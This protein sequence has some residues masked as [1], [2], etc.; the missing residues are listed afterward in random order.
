MALPA[1]LALGLIS[2][3]TAAP[4]G[5]A[6]TAVVVSNVLPRMTTDG[7]IVNAHDS[8]VV[9]DAASGKFYLYGTSFGTN[10]ANF[11][12]C[13]SACMQ[14]MKATGVGFVAYSSASLA[15][16]WKLEG[17]DLTKGLAGGGGDCFKVHRHP[18]TKQYH[19]IWRGGCPSGTS[20]PS[21]TCAMAAVG[22]SPTGPFADPV[23]LARCNR[24]SQAGF[25]VDSKGQGWAWCNTYTAPLWMYSKQCV[26]ELNADWRNATGRS[27][28]WMP[29]D[30]WGL[31]G[32]AIWDRDGTYYFAA[33]SPSCNAKLGGDAR[34]WTATDPLG[35]W[36]YQTNIN[37]LRVPTPGYPKDTP[38]P[39]P[40]PPPP[41]SGGRRIDACD[42]EG[43]WVGG[44]FVHEGGQPLRGGLHITAVSSSALSA[45]EE[46]EATRKQQ[47]VLNFSQSEP[48]L[49][50]I[51]GIGTLAQANSSGVWT[52][53]ITEGLSQNL[54]AVVD[55]WP[56][57]SNGS[58]SRISWSSLAVWGKSPVVPESD[59]HVAA[60]MFGVSTL[61]TAEGEVVHMYTGERYQ[62]G[63]DGQFATGFSYWEPL[64]YASSSAN[65]SG[66][67]Q[68][69]TIGGVDNFSLSFDDEITPLQHRGVKTDDLS[70]RM[71]DVQHGVVDQHDT[72]HDTRHGSSR[73]RIP[74]P[75]PDNCP[76]GSHQ[77]A[78]PC[79]T[80]ADCP[81]W[82][83]VFCTNQTAPWSAATNATYCTFGDVDPPDAVCG[84]AP[85]PP[86][87]AGAKQHLMI[88]DSISFQMNA[89]VTASLAER[90]IET[91][92]VPVN[93]GDTGFIKGCISTWLGTERNRWDVITINSGIHDLTSQPGPNAS[94]PPPP[95]PTKYEVPL[96]D[97]VT[98]LQT[99]VRAMKTN[100]PKAARVWVTTTPCPECACCCGGTPDQWVPDSFHNQ[101]VI[102]YNAAAKNTLAAEGIGPAQTVDLY[103]AITAHK[104]CAVP[105]ET[106]PLQLQHNVH[107]APTGVALNA[108]TLVAGVLLAVQS[109]L[110]ETERL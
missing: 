14:D 80:H 28:C 75:L 99:I 24:S 94:H 108:Q 27:S 98:N 77:K 58:C 36:A 23:T 96:A 47:Q 8:G 4:T 91:V 59:F 70:M 21:Q 50:Q 16:P 43:S 69:L 48:H 57:T 39:P 44:M 12:N 30:G 105:Y 54:T 66:V 93:A 72:Q 74:S 51:Q 15:G 5:S 85:P 3:D 71:I 6:A 42:I 41:E 68:P 45:T 37:P 87:T 18:K 52:I 76:Y 82:P 2:L 55:A 11:N 34:V 10:C 78:L 67:V 25:H 22:D 79:K 110:M 33:G 92:H 63:P 65:G 64:R 89:S 29:R 88:G 84:A 104:G 9:Q 20:P 53:T 86:R 7:R 13:A 90:G 95:K 106:C 46:E 107:F 73:R 60:Q 100:S 38:P 102:S 83:C 32:G 35:E 49:P 40:P 81:H 19:A 101:D 17:T 56:G 97:Y 26:H 62:T 1:V 109:G 103:A 31:E 61:T